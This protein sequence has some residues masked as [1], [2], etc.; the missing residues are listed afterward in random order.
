MIR[1]LGMIQKKRR[2][3]AFCQTYNYYY[4][5]LAHIIEAWEDI[6]FSVLLFGFFEAY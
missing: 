6:Y 5:N 3:Q 2:E 1:I 4:S